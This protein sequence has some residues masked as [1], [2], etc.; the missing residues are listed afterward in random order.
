VLAYLT[1]EETIATMAEIP[2][3]N[4]LFRLDGKVALVTGGT[5]LLDKRSLK[6]A[7]RSS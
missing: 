1:G 5:Y 6:I 2:D 3:F 4:T 7:A